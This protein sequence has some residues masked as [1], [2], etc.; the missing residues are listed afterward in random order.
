[1]AKAIEFLFSKVFDGT[2]W[3][4]IADPDQKKLFAEIRNTASKSV[5]FSCVDLSENVWLWTG[6]TMEEPWWVTISAA[7]KNILLFT[8]YNDSNNPDKKS[9]VA[10]DIVEQKIIW[11]KNDFAVSTV[12]GEI[13]T[14]VNTGL[15]RKEVAVN[16]N[17]GKEI[18]R[19]AVVFGAEQNFKVIRPFQYQQESAHFATV[20]AFLGAKANFLPVITVEYMEYGSLIVIS[21]FASPEDLANYLFV[22]NSDGKLLLTETLGEHLKGIALDTFFVVD[23]FLIFVKNKKELIC[24]KIL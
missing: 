18:P 3:K 7:S 11:W 9:L 15:I 10:F 1:L 16:I 19:D 2:V 22:F 24:Y 14:G 4:T 12:A 17:D 5:S 6:L 21:A 23:G 8:T 13:V 20:R